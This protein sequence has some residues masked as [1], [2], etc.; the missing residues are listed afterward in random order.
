[1]GADCQLDVETTVNA[2][3]IVDSQL[4]KLHIIALPTEEINFAQVDKCPP[5]VVNSL[6]QA[7][8]TA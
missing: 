2:F 3:R 6:A 4:K 5:P 7:S 8:L 1:L